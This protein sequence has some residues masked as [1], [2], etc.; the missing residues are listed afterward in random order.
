MAKIKSLFLSNPEI[1][2]Y[3]VNWQPQKFGKVCN[4]KC[5]FMASTYEMHG[6]F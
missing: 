2:N 3:K 4:S 5:T 1:N 6:K